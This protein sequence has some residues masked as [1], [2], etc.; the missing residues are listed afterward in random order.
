MSFPIDEKIS[1]LHTSE[2]EECESIDTDTDDVRSVDNQLTD[3]LKNFI[4]YSESDTSSDS[5][6][7]P[8][9]FD[10]ETSDTD[11]TD[12]LTALL[13]IVDSMPVDETETSETTKTARVTEISDDEKPLIKKPKLID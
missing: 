5:L 13:D 2:E 3:S 11:V 6:Y 1:Q 10:M 9:T 8:D 4:D 12:E 7:S